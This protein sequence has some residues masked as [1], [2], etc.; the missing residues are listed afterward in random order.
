[1]YVGLTFHKKDVDEGNYKDISL[2]NDMMRIFP[3]KWDRD[4]RF[5][6]LPPWNDSR[7]TY[8]KNN[9]V[10]PFVST[11]IAGDGSDKAL[12]ALIG[13][14]EHLPDFIRL[15]YITN[16]HEPEKDFVEKAGGDVEKGAEAFR[17]SFRAFLD[18][19]DGLPTKIRE[20]IKCG[21]VLTRTWVDAAGRG[22]WKL[23]DPGVGDFFGADMYVLSGGK[24]WVVSPGRGGHLPSAKDFVQSFKEYAFNRS[25]DRPRIWPE[26]GLIGMPTD[27]DGAAR[28]EWIRAVYDEVKTWGTGRPGWKQKWDFEGFVWWQHLGTPTGD[29]PTIGRYRDFRLDYRIVAKTHDKPATSKR[30]ADDPSLPVA[31]YREIIR[32]EHRTVPPGRFVAP[33]VP[34][35]T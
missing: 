18:R 33:G 8:C 27:R 24:D 29:V 19:I 11:K 23:F 22:D 13:Q 9:D 34:V 4:E 7:F 3:N 16:W 35:R 14:L 2:V 28:A 17:T 12:D 25:D 21:P 20:R 5:K 31:A 30:Y 26:L 10:I 6:I 15:L 1:M 32:L